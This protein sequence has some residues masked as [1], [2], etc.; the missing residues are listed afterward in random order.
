[1]SKK[2]V[3]IINTS[4]DLQLK[5]DSLKAI[6]NTL[7][8]KI[9]TF[10]N[11]LRNHLEDA[12][13]EEQELSV[14]YKQQKKAKKE[15]RNLQKT[16]GKKFKE[17]VI[18]ITNESKKTNINNL[19]EEKEKKR[20]YREAMLYVHPDKFSTEIDKLEVATEV[21][22]KLIEIYS[23]SDLKTLKAFHKHILAGS[24]FNTTSIVKNDEKSNYLLLEIEKTEQQIA[25]I[26]NKHTYKVLEE[27]TNPMT[28]LDELKAY[29]D[30]RLF[31][32]RKRTRKG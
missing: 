8:L 2:Q 5:I 28:F 26:K 11:I 25:T 13:I 18:S 32:L 6:L 4:E 22:T 10:E 29:Y 30:D 19:P 12:I 3:T 27:Y 1:M 20:L 23:S 17:G 15:K 14:L 7:E 24:I 31:K 21:T 9:N 16:K